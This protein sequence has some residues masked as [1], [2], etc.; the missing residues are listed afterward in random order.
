MKIALIATALA[1]LLPL[2]AHAE[3]HTCSKYSE[4]R[5]LTLDLNGVKEIVF[6][7]GSSELNLTTGSPTSVQGKACASDPRLLKGL[8]LT[9]QRAGDKLIVTEKED[10]GWHLGSYST[11]LEVTAVIPANLAVGVNVD[12]G[13]ATVH[14]LPS[15]GATVS[16][17]EL[18]ASDIAGNVVVTVSSGE[19]EIE[20]VG[21]VKSAG[22]SSG[23]LKLKQVNG[24]VHVRR[25]SSGELA[26]SGAKG[27]VTIDSVSS[28]EASLENIGG[29]VDIG[30]IGSGEAELDTV[31][32]NV[33]ADSVSSG[34]LKVKHVKGNLSVGAVSSGSVDYHDVA[35]QVSVPKQD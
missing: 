34:E 15:L 32:G 1:A 30:D 24:A 7:V 11:S 14:G 27:D 8:T 23:E 21:T 29:S 3:S 9:Q 35:G 2:A 20:N 4:P 33:H 31:G 18:N 17:G 6:D 13:E 19:A 22:V 16:S 25:V 26:I 28:G 10:N 5:S 12:S